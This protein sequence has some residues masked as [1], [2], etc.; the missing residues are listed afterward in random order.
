MA[1]K[2]LFILEQG[3]N[4]NDFQFLN[5]AC[6]ANGVTYVVVKSDFPCFGISLTRF[7]ARAE[8]DLKLAMTDF[9]QIKDVE[10]SIPF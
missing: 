7:S 1:D 4:D 10:M 5:P 2:E 3:I 9:Q 8:S 6:R